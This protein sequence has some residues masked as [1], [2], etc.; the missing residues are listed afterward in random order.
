MTHGGSLLRIYAPLAALVA[1]ICLAEVIPGGPVAPIGL[2]GLVLAGLRRRPALSLIGLV[3]VASSCGV[4]VTTPRSEPVALEQLA[5]RIPFCTV[6]GRLLEHGSGLGS[7]VTA[8]A[9]SCDGYAPGVE[10]GVVVVEPS[11]VDPGSSIMLT[12][13]LLPLRTDD[14]FDQARRRLG[15]HAAFHAE[16]T[17]TTDA[18]GGLHG[19]AAGVRAG[20]ERATSGMEAERAGLLSGLTTGDTSGMSYE[21]EEQLR[22]AGLS[23]L[24]AVS[25]S[26]VAIVVGAAALVVARFALWARLVVC[27]AALALFVLVV[28]PEPSVLRAAAMGCVGLAAL[29]F[30]RRAEPLHALGLALI[31]VLT[32][33]PGLVFSVGLH[34]S[35]TATAGIVIFAGG[36]ARRMSWCPRPVALVLAATL[37]AQIAVAPVLV[38]TFGEFSLVA[39]IANLLAVPAVAPATVLGVVAAVAGVFVPPLGWLCARAAEPFVAWVLAVGKSTGAWSWASVDV[40]EWWGWP[41]GVLVAAAAVATFRSA[42][43][44]LDLPGIGAAARGTKAK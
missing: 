33:R 35:A 14:R 21:T 1:G 30:G 17:R 32:L 11:D 34:L 10:A 13:W 19:L 8:E 3:L 22:R 43:A 40:P 44:T 5:E 18:P 23:H 27:V 9:V 16:E 15:A 31:V 36:L 37:A 7:L 29:A 24:V 26:N 12:G 4:L 42:G 20:L 38:G 41:L 25:G 39:P 28:G 6:T 2:C